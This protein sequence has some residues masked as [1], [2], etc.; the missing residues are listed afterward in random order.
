MFLR[1]VLWE[2]CFPV[3]SV[4]TSRQVEVKCVSPGNALGIAVF[5]HSSYLAVIRFAI[6]PRAIAIIAVI[7]MT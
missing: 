6:T 1:I 7:P 3:N 5:D 4:S 2:A